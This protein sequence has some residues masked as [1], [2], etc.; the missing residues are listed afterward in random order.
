MFEFSE[1]LIEGQV[2]PTGVSVIIYVL[3]LLLFA[4]CFMLLSIYFSPTACE[5][6]WFARHGKLVD[7]TVVKID[8]C[9]AYAGYATA[10]YY[11]VQ[12]RWKDMRTGKLHLVSS[13]WVCRSSIKK[14]ENPNL[15]RDI[16]P[17]EPIKVLVDPRNPEH[18]MIVSLLPKTY[19]GSSYLPA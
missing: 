19:E 2:I 15:P 3:I 13:G 16:A 10:F 6:R 14:R 17:G 5:M 12:A 9:R 8:M 1:Q 18:A 11:S 7:A 4:V